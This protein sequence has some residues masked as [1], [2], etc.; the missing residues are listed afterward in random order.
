MFGIIQNI[1]NDTDLILHSSWRKIKNFFGNY[2][3]CVVV[4]AKDNLN[5]NSKTD[6]VIDYK[7]QTCLGLTE[8]DYSIGCFNEDNNYDFPTIRTIEF[9]DEEAYTLFKLRYTE[10][11]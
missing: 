6:D 4:E 3:Y 10:L 9:N 8:A 7:L 11:D 1:S 2:N 5:K